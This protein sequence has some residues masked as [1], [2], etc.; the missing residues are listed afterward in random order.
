MSCNKI[1][2]MSCNKILCKE[3]RICKNKEIID[4]IN[5]GEQIITSRFTVYGD[6]STPSIPIILCL[7]TNCSLVQL[8]YSTDACELYEHEYGYRSGISN[9]MKEHL[10]K[11]QEEIISKIHLNK[12]DAIVDIGS[13]DSTMLQYYDK[14]YKRIGVD[15]TGKQFKEFYGD[16]EL[17]PNYFTYQNFRDVYSDIKP[18]IVSSI[19]MFYDLPDPVKF[20]KDIYEILDDDGIWTC[21]QSYLIT[22]LR[23]NSIDTICHEHLEYYSLTAIKHIADM[24][25]FN[26]IDIKFNECNGGSFRLYFAKKTSNIFLENI[27]LINKIIED[28]INYDIKNPQI[29]TN[30]LNRCDLEVKKLSIFID[31]VN[32]NGQK[33]YIYGASTKGNCLLQYAK[34]YENKIKYAVERNLNKIGKMTSTGI[35]IISEETMRMNQPEYLLVLPWH[36]RDEIIKR[37]HEFLEKGGQLIFPF[38]KFEIYS[39]KKKVLITGCDG[40]IAR[41]IIEEYNDGNYNLFGFS[42]KNIEQS[43]NKITKFDFDIKN[44]DELEFNLK[45]IKP[46]IVIHLAGISSSIEA[47]KNPIN[48]IELNGMCVAHICDIIHKNKWSTKLFNASSSEMFKGHIN[49]TVTDDDKNMYHIHPYSIAKIMGH[50]I[51]NFYKNTFNLPFSNGILF[52]IES[53]YKK[54]DFLLNKIV[55]HAR[56]W[57]ENNEIIKLGSLDSYRT[58]LHAS[59]AAKAIKLILSQTN[60]DNYVICGNESIKIIDLVFKI[61]NLNGINANMIDNTIFSNNKIVAII[62]NNNKGIDNSPINISGQAEKLRNLGW[63]PS[64]TINDIINEI[65]NN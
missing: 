50:S 33:M 24:A 28:E 20:A 1:Y 49:Y 59:D 51:V 63:R 53:K 7:C 5:V 14:I 30:F 4:I 35:G 44:I 12:G 47:F 8:K 43:N 54:G 52:T 61:Y 15:P 36:F 9:T 48:T 62:E 41:Y 22:M 18:K 32:K 23:R 13:N 21:E 42:H 6:F 2:I 31:A 25:G 46:D 29:Y 55:K 57:R 37:E 3:C 56:I 16:V 17:I 39:K 11:Y 34:I 26:I 65:N 40:M 10:K 38:P 19:S 27:E 60:G 64:Y 58:I 45:I